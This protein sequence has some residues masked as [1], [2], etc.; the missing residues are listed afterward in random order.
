[1]AKAKKEDE[2]P[3]P[4]QVEFEPLS[5]A[6]LEAMST[7]DLQKHILRVELH[8][9]ML[10]LAQAARSNEQYEEA[11]RRRRAANRQR[12]KELKDARLAQERIERSCRHR[13]GGTPDN[14]LRGG[15]IGSFSTVTRAIMPDGVTVF[16]QCP[17]CRLKRYTPEVH[18][19]HEDPKRYAKELDEY[20]ELLEASIE[21][22]LAPL[23][24]PTFT[25]T[26]SEGVPIIPRRV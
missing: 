3:E 7:E 8:T 5:R 15:G 19:K 23:R 26:N 2:N 1:M 11:E 14:I 12:M 25:F 17:R 21:N 16:M 4:E 13:S 9:K 24:G 18:L 22:G 20:N 10:Q 6:D